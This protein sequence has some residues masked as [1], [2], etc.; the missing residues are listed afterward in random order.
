[1][2]WKLTKCRRRRKEERGNEEDS[3]PIIDNDCIV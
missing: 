3:G 1:M 2:D